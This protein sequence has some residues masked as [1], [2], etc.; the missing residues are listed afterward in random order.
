MKGKIFKEREGERGRPESTADSS[1][2]ARR[3]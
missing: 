2:Q 1:R 3:P